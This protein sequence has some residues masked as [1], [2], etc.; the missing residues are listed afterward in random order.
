MAV[1][2]PPEI[3][4]I[5]VK[6][7]VA[8]S[9]CQYEITTYFTFEDI[10]SML[11]RHKNAEAWNNL[12]LV[13]HAFRAHAGQFPHR[14]LRAHTNMGSISNDLISTEIYSSHPGFQQLLDG[15]M[16]NCQQLV[17]LVIDYSTSGVHARSGSTALFGGLAFFPNLRKLTLSNFIPIDGTSIWKNLNATCPSL[18]CLHL[19]SRY[20][21]KPPRDIVVFKRLEVLAVRS[22]F[23]ASGLEFPSL[24]HAV[25]QALSPDNILQIT[26][27]RKLE[28]L[29]LENLDDNVHFDWKLVPKLRLLRIP[30]SRLSII[31]SCQIGHP[32]NTLQVS[33]PES[34]FPSPKTS[35]G[36]AF[37]I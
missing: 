21:Q 10:L 11:R 25:L 7:A 1:T 30:C 17:A 12:R 33:R 14:A 28:S 36:S 8:D 13:C 26:Q 37:D 4:A 32:L 27:S 3:W 15:T 29:H 5:I 19:S 16:A 6:M 9:F 31:K 2:L 20:S 34:G 24:R 23:S 35:S 18:T 22:Q